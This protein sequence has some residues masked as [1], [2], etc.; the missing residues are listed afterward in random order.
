MN[1]AT[2]RSYNRSRE[3]G[4]RKVLGASL[5]SIVYLFSKEF[6]ILIGVAF[7][8][9]APLTWYF[10]HQWLQNFQYRVSVNG[11]VFLLGGVASMIVALVTVSFKAIR[12][13]KTN[14]VK[15]L[16]SE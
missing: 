10:L 7:A 13:A 1:L 6:I 3:V 2:A 9:A 5:Q 8:I 15:T 12:A 4:V 16:R 14:P 11:W